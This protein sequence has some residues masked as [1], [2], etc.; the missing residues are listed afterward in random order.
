MYLGYT[1]L[2]VRTVLFLLLLLGV[3]PALAARSVGYEMRRVHGVTAHVVTVNLND[4]RI[5]VSVQTPL[6][7]FGHAEPFGSFIRRS[8]PVAAI[9]GTFFGTRSLL[10]VGDIV[11]NG[12][13]VYSGPA[14]TGFCVAPDNTVDFHPRRYGRTLDWTG[15]DTVLCTGPTLLRNGRNALYPRDEGYRDRSL[16]ARK[17][18]TAVGLTKNNKMLMVAVNRP[19][20]LRTMVVVMQQLGAVNAVGLDGGSSSALY[21][22]GKTVVRP[23]RHLTNVLTVHQ[24]SVPRFAAGSQTSPTVRLARYHGTY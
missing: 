7:G 17:P 11:R 9:T 16:Y 6:R 24:S 20:Y 22:A 2:A 5:R 15:Y 21:Y 10:P 12:R 8:Y 23:G 3:R 18:R 4:P 1:Q 13:Q 19:I 14:G